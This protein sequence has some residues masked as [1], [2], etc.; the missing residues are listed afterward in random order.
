MASKTDSPTDWD[1]MWKGRFGRRDVEGAMWKGSVT[2][3]R[4]E[5]PRLVAIAPRRASSRIW[6]LVGSV[7]AASLGLSLPARAA[8]SDHDQALHPQVQP[9]ELSDDDGVYG[10]FA[11]DLDAGLGLGV[12]VLPDST[13]AHAELSLLYFSLSGVRVGYSDAF[14]NAAIERDLSVRAEI[15]PLF[16]P[17][18]QANREQGPGYL[19]LLLDSFTLGLGAYWEQSSGNAFGESRGL[20]G[21]IGLGLPALPSAEG[22][23]L[24]AALIRR[25]PDN[26]RASTAFTLSL[27][28]HWVFSSGLH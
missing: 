5:E 7:V 28:W 8:N 15:K 9:L 17:R 18:W 6:C 4:Q 19:D 12:E 24:E 20:E 14:G 13:L 23:W 22:L 25:W 16:I 27:A 1:P 26:T 3:E 2:A 11:G 10:R 21:A